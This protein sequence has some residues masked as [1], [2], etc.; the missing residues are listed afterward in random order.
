MVKISPVCGIQTNNIL[1][2]IVI[3]IIIIIIYNIDNNNLMQI[4]NLTEDNLIDNQL[5]I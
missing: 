5:I 3:I 2:K 1:I 4:D